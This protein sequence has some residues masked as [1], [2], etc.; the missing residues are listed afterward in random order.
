MSMMNDPYHPILEQPGEY[1]VFTLQFWQW[2]NAESEPFIDI[3]LKS[4]AGFRDLRFL[5]PKDLEIE[6]GFPG[7]T[8]GFCIFDVSRKG[9]EGLNVRVD[10]ISGDAGA[11]RFW[12]REVIKCGRWSRL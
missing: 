6:K 10:S 12:A 11:V 2:P 1:E 3:T 4:A 7:K 8:R 9:I 5:S